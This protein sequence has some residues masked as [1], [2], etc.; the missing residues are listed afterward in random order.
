[1][2][3][4]RRGF[5]VIDLIALIAL[6]LVLWLAAAQ[7]FR[8]YAPKTAAPAQ[9]AASPPPTVEGSPVTSGGDTSPAGSSNLT[10]DPPA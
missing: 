4:S 10:A 1:M 7:Q 2:I 6:L 9:P 5:G 8:E 3:R